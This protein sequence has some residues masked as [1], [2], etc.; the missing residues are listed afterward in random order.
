VYTLD[1]TRLFAPAG[2]LLCGHEPAAALCAG[3]LGALEEITGHGCQACGNPSVSAH[4]H[5]CTWCRRLDHLGDVVCSCFAYRG[6]G[7]ELYQTIKF[8]GYWR[9]IRPLVER[10]QRAFFAGL[11]YP[12]YACLVPVPESKRR[13]IRRF[14]DPAAVI[15]EEIRRFTGL[16][17]LRAVTNRWWHRQ[18]VGLDYEKRKRNAA[19]RFLVRGTLPE[20]VILVDDVITTGATLEAITRRLREAGVEHVAW[21]SLF[22][23]P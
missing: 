5:D 1:F 6:T 21:F 9:L 16:P 7:L 14:F 18:Q 8:G 10:A 15:A 22:R 19:D 12:E 17:V 3:C 11:P 2:C 23:T 4:A 13:R 20:R